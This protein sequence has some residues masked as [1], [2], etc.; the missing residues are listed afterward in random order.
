MARGDERPGDI[1]IAIWR[2]AGAVTGDAEAAV[3]IAARITRVHADLGRVGESRLQRLVEEGA[4]EWSVLVDAGEA[5]PGPE[6]CPGVLGVEARR[7]HLATRRPDPETEAPRIVEARRAGAAGRRRTALLQLGLLAACM[8]VLCYVIFDLMNWD[9]REA[10]LKRDVERL[11]NP[12]P[13][14]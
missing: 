7:S 1:E 14:D 12:L 5:E 2:E 8:L 13:D 3:R 9:E 4:A 11:S 10:M 6:L